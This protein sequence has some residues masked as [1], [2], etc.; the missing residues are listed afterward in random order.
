MFENW[1]VQ[2]SPPVRMDVSP[3]MPVVL[4]LAAALARS[5]MSFGGSPPLRVLAE[6]LDMDSKVEG[7]LHAWARTSR[8]DWLGFCQFTVLSGNGRGR[9]SMQQWCPSSSI[10][11]GPAGD[12][13]DP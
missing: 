7:T 12:A 9:L 4:D 1:P 13:V 11:P 3:P 2:Y 10:T 6:G 8:G 5:P